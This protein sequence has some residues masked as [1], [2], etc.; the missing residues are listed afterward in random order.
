MDALTQKLQTYK[1]GKF[2]YLRLYN[3]ALNRRLGEV[4]LTFLYPEFVN[5]I[6]D[7]VRAEVLEFAKENLSI[8]SKILVKFKRSFL[9]ERLLKKRILQFLEDNF[10]SIFSKFSLEQIDIQKDG[11]KVKITLSM[12][13]EVLRTYEGSFVKKALLGDLNDNF[14]AEFEI[15][16]I[17]D[18]T[19]AIDDEVP[20]VPV[21]VRAK[22]ATR[23]EVE[24]VKSLFGKNISP[25]PE[26]IR[27]NNAPKSGLILFGTISNLVRK[28]FVAKSGRSKGQEKT[29]YVF[30]LNDGNTIECIYFCTK[31]NEKKCEVL[32]DGMTFL[33]LG[34]LKPNMSN[35]LTY[36]ISAMTYAQIKTPPPEE[37][38]D[39]FDHIPVV[40]IEDFIDHAQSNFFV[41]KPSYND[42]ITGNDIVVYDLETTGLDSETCEIIEIGAIKIEKG[43]ITKKFSSFVKPK[44]PIPEDATRINHITNEM[45]ADAPKIEDV[46]VDFYNFCEGCIISGYNNTSFDNKFLKKAGMKVGLKFNHRNLDV[47]T[48]AS[49][50]HL[51]THNL[52]L[53]TVSAAL[54]IDLTGAHRAYNDAFATAKV[55]LKLSKA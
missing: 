50:S 21:T 2:A 39:L 10:K 29:Y 42:T 27:N 17:E 14:L 18:E 33:C 26:L 51:G 43:K 6:S 16:E 38:I 23:Y 47:F 31:T 40:E 55:L 52:K 49:A 24:I 46:I 25:Y 37:E 32:A 45:V 53:G 41:Q 8:S 28:T 19:Y 30:N 35:K 12:C 15:V 22:K 48:L 13:Q 4:E 3:V 5:A 34:D 11:Q 20:D 44:T 7:D 54:G 9:D 36:Y 1:E